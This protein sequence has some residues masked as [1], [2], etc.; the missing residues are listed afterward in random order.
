MRDQCV[1]RR[2]DFDCD[3]S[4]RRAAGRGCRELLDENSVAIQEEETAPTPTCV[5]VQWKLG[6]LCDQ[7][8]GV[9]VLWRL[10]SLDFADYAYEAARKVTRQTC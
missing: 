1:S 7:S 9:V 6:C 5:R 3:K 4:L 8:E 2:H 10:R